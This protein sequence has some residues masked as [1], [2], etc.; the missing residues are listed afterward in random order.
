MIDI[1]VKYQCVDCDTEIESDINNVV[2]DICEE[3]LKK[4]KIYEIRD[5][6]R[7]SFE[8]ADFEHEFTRFENKDF[9]EKWMRGY[10]RGIHDALFWIADYFD[11]IE[12]FEEL[13]KDSKIGRKK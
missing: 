11:Q 2:V 9:K 7:S 10:E 5:A 6:M 4:E 3:C 8:Q 12:F 13:I 1:I